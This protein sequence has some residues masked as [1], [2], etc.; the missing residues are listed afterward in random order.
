M[1]EA[2]TGGLAEVRQLAVTSSP[3]AVESEESSTS[4]D[5]FA[6]KKES[7]RSSVID[8]NR[9]VVRTTRKPQ[10]LNY[11]YLVFF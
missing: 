11:S 6:E 5:G 7:G 2:T 9:F 8:E 10:D 1:S 3:S 4:I